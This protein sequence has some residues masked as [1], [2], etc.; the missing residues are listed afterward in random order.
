LR[1]A[2]AAEMHSPSNYNKITK[3]LAASSAPSFIQSLDRI[4][5]FKNPDVPST[6]MK[7]APDY[8]SIY[9]IAKGKSVNVRLAKCSVTTAVTGADISLES[10]DSFR[11]T[12]RGSRGHLPP[13]TPDASRRSIDGR[14]VPELTTRPPFRER[15]LPSHFADGSS[16]STRRSNS[17][18]SLGSDLDFSQ[19][20]RFSNVD[21][22]VDN[23]DM[24]ALV[25]GTP[26]LEPM[27]PSAGVS[28]TAVVFV[29]LCF[30]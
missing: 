5:K 15:S 18:D 28:S 16:R 29:V 14:M 9:V 21:C 13:A 2:E 27:S 22:F 17:H 10:S 11:Y 4:R 23:L 20:S 24:S 26:G 12:R 19:S 7:C 30:T 1:S 6:L 8:C 25:A 3:F